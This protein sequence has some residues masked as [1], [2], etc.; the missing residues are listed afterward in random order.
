MVSPAAKLV[1]VSDVTI[2]MLQVT[3]VNVSDMAAMVRNISTAE[4]TLHEC[5]STTLNNT[6]DDI[7][8]NRSIFELDTS[9]FWM[10]MTVM[11]LYIMPTV[12]VL[13]MICNIASAHY[14][15]EE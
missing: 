5:Y 15:A 7:M 8:K 13:G 1:R 3:S 2:N 9:R 4:I 6:T 11:H 10:F 14:I 12:A